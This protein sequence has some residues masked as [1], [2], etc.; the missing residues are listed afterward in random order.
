MES[1]APYLANNIF[2][3]THVSKE[4]GKRSRPG[5]SNGDR[6]N[7]ST[8]GDTKSGF[9]SKDRGERKHSLSNRRSSFSS[10]SKGK[11]R[12]SSSAADGGGQVVTDDARPP[13]LPDFALAAAAK[14]A[15]E[16]EVAVYSPSSVDSFSRMLSRT[17]PN[18]ANGYGNMTGVTSASVSQPSAGLPV[19]SLPQE[20]NIIYQHVQEITNKRISTLDYLRKACVALNIVR[21]AA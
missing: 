4:T 13:A 20:S 8:S 12:P 14:L 6:S 2:Y 21:H 16:N 3:N 10:P 17:A 9:F 18:S 5:T 15:R 19:G 7:S 1:A 11:R